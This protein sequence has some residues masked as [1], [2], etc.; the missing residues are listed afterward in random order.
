MPGDSPPW[1]TRRR[2]GLTEEPVVGV[3]LTGENVI[4]AP[5]TVRAC[6]PFDAAINT[7]GSSSCTRPDGVD[8]RL[9]FSVTGQSRIVVERLPT[10][11]TVPGTSLVT[12]TKTVE[13]R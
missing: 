11:G 13:V 12:V 1:C 8:V 3:I 4:D 7:F 6:E 2:A 5:D 9:Q 10:S